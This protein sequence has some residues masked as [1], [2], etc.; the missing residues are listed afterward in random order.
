MTAMV[1]KR[2]HQINMPRP[3]A[4]AV[5]ALLL[6][7]RRAQARHALSAIALSLREFVVNGLRLRRAC[8]QA[9]FSP[10]GRGANEVFG[11]WRCR[12]P[13]VPI[14]AAAHLGGFGSG[15]VQCVK[16]GNGVDVLAG[17]GRA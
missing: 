14:H 16:D 2:Q 7:Q 5:H 4:Y 10:G 12:R 6:V 17:D 13:G 8:T 15:F 9:G 3:V 11:L 1:G